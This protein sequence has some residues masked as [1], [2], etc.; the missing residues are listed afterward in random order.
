MG[1][2]LGIALTIG[3]FFLL[4]HRRTAQEQPHTSPHVSAP[5]S[6]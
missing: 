6:K 5:A 3:V 2:L 1:I 4:D